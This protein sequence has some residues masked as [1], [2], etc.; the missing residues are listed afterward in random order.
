MTKKTEVKKKT[1]KHFKKESGKV[2]NA[3]LVKSDQVAISWRI[4]EFKEMQAIQ[5]EDAGD[6]ADKFAYEFTQTINGRDVIV[7]GIRAVG[8]REA[9]RFTKV[10]IYNFVPVFD[11]TTVD[12]GDGYYREIVNCKN[13]KTGEITSSSAQ[14]RRGDRFSDRTART[15]AERNA[16]IKQLPAEIRLK[17][18]NYCVNQGYIAKLNVD[19][20]AIENAEVVK[21][22]PPATANEAGKETSKTIAQIYAIFAAMNI[23]TACARIWIHKKYKVKSIKDLDDVTITRIKNGL[24]DIEYNVPGKCAKPKQNTM[25]PDELKAEIEG[26]KYDNE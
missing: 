8:A 17:F 12:L 13:P 11:Y 1:K 21:Q 25:T 9:I 3:A 7:R 24:K 26:G 16:M 10:A 4:L 22:L 6:L 2:I 14:W 15:I 20:D 18:I 23:K 5:A 19:P